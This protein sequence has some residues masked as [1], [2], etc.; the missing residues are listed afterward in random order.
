MR[1]GIDIQYISDFSES[2]ENSGEVFLRRIFT[3]NE[4]GCDKARMR[5]MEYLCGRFSAKEACIKAGFAG[6][7]EWHS[8]E[9]IGDI[10]VISGGTLSISHSHGF[11]VAVA[12]KE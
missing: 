6:V 8:L 5:D 2:Y 11:V 3:S 10:P 7:G 1:I 4:L 9:L 12:V